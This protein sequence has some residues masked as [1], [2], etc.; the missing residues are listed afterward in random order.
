MGI[1][2][3]ILLLGIVGFF[4][5][6]AI[7]K[8]P[9]TQFRI[10]ELLLLYQLLFSVGAASL[11]SFFGLTLMPEFV[12]HYS[13][14][15]PGQ[16]EQLLANVNLAFSVLGAM[17]I[18]LRG[19]FWT[20]VVIGS[21]IWLLGDA[22]WHVIDAFRNHNWAPGNVGILLYTDFLIPI[23]LC[24]LLSFYLKLKKA[25]QKKVQ[26]P[27]PVKVKSKPV[28]QDEPIEE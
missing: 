6:I 25:E 21:S 15:R 26:V 13:G 2:I 1:F 7:S 27:V 14:W 19:K 12:A 11:L 23:V 3:G 5:H 22:I 4:V 24:V 20:A 16:F 17:C 10:V 8:K 9:R 28:Y 18:W